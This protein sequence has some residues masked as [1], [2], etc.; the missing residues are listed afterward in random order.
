MEYLVFVPFVLVLGL[1]LAKVVRHGGVK[2]AM[3]GATVGRAVGEM[4]VSSDSRVGS[5]TLKVHL[6]EG[7]EKQ[8]G[9]E[10][11]ARGPFGF[12]MVPVAL[13]RSEARRLADL[14][15]AAIGDRPVA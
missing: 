10:I 4:P 6:L 13:T 9:V 8:V 7:A 12:S 11:A 2:A 5:M 3:F 14:L 15:L 1:M